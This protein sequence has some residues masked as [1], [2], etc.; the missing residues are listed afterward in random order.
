MTSA[1]SEK[2]AYAGALTSLAE[3]PMDRWPGALSDIYHPDVAWHG[4]HPINVR[5]GSRAVL[6]AFWAPFLSALPDV[7]RRDD[8]LIAGIFNDGSWVGATG[9]YTGTFRHDWL[10]IR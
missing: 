7:E 10:G 8:I 1:H 2:I 4:P 6:E 3:R 5:I 9:Y